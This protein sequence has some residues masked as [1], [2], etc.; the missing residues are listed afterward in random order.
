MIA[1]GLNWSEHPANTKWHFHSL[2]LIN[3]TVF[4]SLMRNY[5]CKIFIQMIT[6]HSFFD[7][8]QNFMFWIEFDWSTMSKSNVKEVSNEICSYNCI[9]LLPSLSFVTIVSLWEP[10]S[11]EGVFFINWPQLVYLRLFHIRIWISRFV[12]NP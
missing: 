3:C 9:L 4:L 1:N 10:H 6:K 7:L 12:I 2:T 5:A 8:L 11:Q